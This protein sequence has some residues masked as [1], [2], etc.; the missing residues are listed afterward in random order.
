MMTKQT[1]K[2]NENGET[3]KLFLL[4]DDSTTPVLWQ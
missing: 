2:Q 3:T 4:T 1:N